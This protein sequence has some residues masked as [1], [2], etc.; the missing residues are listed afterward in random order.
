MD[1]Y[2]KKILDRFK[3][4]KYAGKIEKP[5]AVGEVG[6]IRCGD[7]MKVFIKVEKNKHGKEIIKDISY[8][9]YGCAAAIVSSDYLCEIAKGKTLEK[10]KK[11]TS[12][13]VI[14]K[15][16]KVPLIKIHCSVLA[17]N[18]LHKAI[19]DYKKKEKKKNEQMVK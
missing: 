15:M 3:N 17:Q 18:A 10:A 16:G 7:V 2:S 12:K 13:D 14:K 9:T 11:I 8:Q 19:E 5:S 4:P 1:I 6:N